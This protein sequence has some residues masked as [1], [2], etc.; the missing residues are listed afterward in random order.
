MTDSVAKERRTSSERPNAAADFFGSLQCTSCEAADIFSEITK[1]SLMPKQ[2]IDTKRQE[3]REKQRKAGSQKPWTGKG[4]D[5]DRT[6]T[7]TPITR[8]SS[9]AYHREADS[10]FHGGFPR[11]CELE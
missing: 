3:S 4:T 10:T 11:T 9:E 7:A 1:T 2:Q 6:R 8:H 5:M